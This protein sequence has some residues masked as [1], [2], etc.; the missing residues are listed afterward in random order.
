MSN[1][2]SVIEFC[3]ERMEFKPFVAQVNHGYSPE[4]R[5]LAKKVVANN[6]VSTEASARE[7]AEAAGN[8]ICNADFGDYE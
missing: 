6:K 4:I 5:A 8:W 1:L 3:E 2:D 7:W